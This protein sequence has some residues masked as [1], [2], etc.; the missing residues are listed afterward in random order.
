[1]GSAQLCPMPCV[2]RET[3]DDAQR[4]PH[5]P[6][7]PPIQEK[8]HGPIP[9]REKSG[10]NS[11]PYKPPA[12]SP[13]LVD[14]S[15]TRPDP[16]AGTPGRPRGHRGG[17]GVAS[18]LAAGAAGDGDT[19]VIESRRCDS[20]GAA[21][22]LSSLEMPFPRCPSSAA[23]RA[24]HQRP[25]VPSAPS[26]RPRGPSGSEVRRLRPPGSPEEINPRAPWERPPE[27]WRK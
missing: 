27:R 2:Q 1:M 26:P 10:I 12:L 9:H 24:P 4:V 13:L 15:R 19:P 14:H 11:H 7:R 5:H 18:A 21:A 3:R 6:P 8:I 17:T 23:P 22:G 20:A 16:S 25:R